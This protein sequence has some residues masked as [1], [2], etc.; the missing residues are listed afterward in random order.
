MTVKNQIIAK[1]PSVSLPRKLNNNNEEGGGREGSEEGRNWTNS[2]KK[3][4]FPKHGKK[5]PFRG[6][7]KI[8]TLKAGQKDIKVCRLISCN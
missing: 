4:A 1:V 5:V 8:W 6:I 2:Q 7:I 3:A